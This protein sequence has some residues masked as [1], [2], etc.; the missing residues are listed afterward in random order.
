M[1][2]ILP[3]KSEFSLQDPPNKK[4]PEVP[5]FPSASVVGGGGWLD[6][7]ISLLH[8]FQDERGHLVHLRKKGVE[9]FATLK[10]IDYPQFP[11]VDE[12]LETKKNKK[13]NQLETTFVT[14]PMLTNWNC[15]AQTNLS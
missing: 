12:F 11:F 14:K 15:W 5:P 1:L 9:M 10:E 8:L 2:S 13:V 7:R 6:L 3:E 4:L